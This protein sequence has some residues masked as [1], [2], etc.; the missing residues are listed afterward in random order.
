MSYSRWSNSKWYT[1]WEADDVL[2]KEQEKFCI[3]EIDENII[4]TYKEISSNI[5]DCLKKVSKQSKCSDKELKELKTYMK[6]FKMDVDDEYK[7]NR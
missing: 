6:R 4:F 7:T 1:F 5:D 2:E 3:C